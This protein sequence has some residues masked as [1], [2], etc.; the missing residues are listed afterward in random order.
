MPHYKLFGT[1]GCHLC[2]LAESLLNECGTQVSL[3]WQPVEIADDDSLLN[4]YGIR[5]P[6]LHC[7]DSGEELDWPFDA[8]QLLAFVAQK[9]R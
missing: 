7:S 5:I 6:V 2:E 4:S 1:S 8:Q 3:D 9:G